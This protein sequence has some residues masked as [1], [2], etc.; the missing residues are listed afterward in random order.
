MNRKFYPVDPGLR[1]SVVTASGADQGKSL[2]CAVFA[3]L[4]RRYREIYYWRGDGEVDF[5]VREGQE[6]QPI[7]VTWD[8][9]KPRHEKALGSFYEAFPQAK[10]AI[11]ITA[12]SFGAMTLG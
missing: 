12:E 9:L 2:E 6:I 11:T 1:R 10:E 3:A 5:V 4:R 8:D 7:Q